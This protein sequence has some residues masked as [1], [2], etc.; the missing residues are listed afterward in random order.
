MAYYY[1]YNLSNFN[2]TFAARLAALMAYTQQQTGERVT[3]GSGVRGSLEQAGLYAKYV[4][5]GFNPQ[6]IAA[7]PGMS[8]HEQGM[9]A[10]IRASPKALAFM[11]RYGYQFGLEGATEPDR[12]ARNFK[13][14]PV[15]F[16][17]A[18]SVG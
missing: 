14:D 17:L 13:V 6:Y 2:N 12:K 10:D 1:G 9:A 7:P 4:A 15:H 3:I 11:H 16:Q 18:R 5:S 8:L